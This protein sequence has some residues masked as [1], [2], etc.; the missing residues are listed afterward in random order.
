[1]TWLWTATNTPPGITAINDRQVNVLIRVM[2]SNVSINYF[3]CLISGCKLLMFKHNHKYQNSYKVDFKCATTLASLK[4]RFQGHCCAKSNH[5]HHHAV[6]SVMLH[7]SVSLCKYTQGSWITPFP[8][9]LFS[10]RNNSGTT[11]TTPGCWPSQLL[12]GAPAVVLVK[13]PCQQPNY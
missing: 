9:M 4:R 10:T 7:T 11:V 6:V 13:L 8:F 1:M 12:S 2:P 3:F 5:N